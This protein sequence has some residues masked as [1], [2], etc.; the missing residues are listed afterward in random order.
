MGNLAS[1]FDVMPK[2]FDDVHLS[3][4]E[5]VKLTHVRDNYFDDVY[6]STDESVKLLHVH[7][8]YP[9]HLTMHTAHT[10]SSL[11][12]PPPSCFRC[13]S[14]NARTALCLLAKC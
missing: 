5:G 14:Y 9:I 4:D 7:V 6:L 10:A 11:P 2:S 8:I 12:P 1:A 13:S 3:F